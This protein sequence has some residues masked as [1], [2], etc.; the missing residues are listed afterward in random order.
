MTRSELTA[1][2]WAIR[3]EQKWSAKDAYAQLR[4]IVALEKALK[5]GEVEFYFR[6]QNGEVRTA[7]G[8]LNPEL[9]GYLPQGLRKPNIRI[10][11]YWD[12]EKNEFRSFNLWSYLGMAG[13]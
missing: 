1:R 6:K 5:K 13:V 9:F 11:V 7:K 10:F 4:K 3:R 2:V 12:L 8:T